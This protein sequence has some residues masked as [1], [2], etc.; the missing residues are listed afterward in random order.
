MI[1]FALEKLGGICRGNG[2]WELDE[3]SVAREAAQ[4]TFRKHVKETNGNMR[5]SIDDFL[6]EWTMTTPGAMSCPPLEYLKV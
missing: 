4:A 3:R 2:L 5:M 6:E 1:Q